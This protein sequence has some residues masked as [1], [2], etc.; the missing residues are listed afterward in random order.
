MSIENDLEIYFRENTGNL[1]HKWSHYFAIYDRHFSRFR[2]AAPNVIEFGVSH[3]G[4]LQMWK[5]YFGPGCHIYGVD[6]DPRCKQ[7]EEDQIEIIIGDQANREFLRSLAARIP[8]LD[9][10]IDDGG[11]RMAQQINTFE[12][13]FHHIDIEG[14]YLCEDICTSYWRGWGGG[15]RKR[16]TFIEYSKS[17]VDYLNAWH[18]EDPRRLAVSKFTSSVDSITYYDNVVVI[19]KRPREK[20]HTRKTGNARLPIG[21]A[22]SATMKD[23]L[24]RAYERHIGWRFKK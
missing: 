11:H 23:A 1:I 17:F 14:V 18:S 24:Q 3:G 7:F 4:S 10:L 13:L 9:I 2:G 19:E 21:G 6:I 12:E 20:P 8:K 22:S 16:G 5:Q 15:Y